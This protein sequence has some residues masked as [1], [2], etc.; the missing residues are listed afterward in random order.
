M[1]TITGQTVTIYKDPFTKKR[2]EGKARLAEFLG[3]V[4]QWKGQYI[5]YWQVHFADGNIA[6]RKILV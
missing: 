1:R 3:R 4:G 5:E 6:E 2:P